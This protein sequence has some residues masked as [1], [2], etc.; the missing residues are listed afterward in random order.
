[1]RVFFLFILYMYFIN[2]RRKQDESKKNERV[3][4]R[5]ERKC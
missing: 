2:E 5:A 1:M 3:I 4:E